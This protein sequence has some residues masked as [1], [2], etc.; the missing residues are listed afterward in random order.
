MMKA[1]LATVQHPGGFPQ[2]DLTLRDAKHQVVFTSSP[3]APDTS[4]TSAASRWSSSTANCSS[5]RRPFEVEPETWTLQTGF[6]T[7]PSRRSPSAS[8]R[9]QLA[10]MAL[11][12]AVMAAGV[13]FVAGA[14]ARE[15]RLAELKS[16]F[17]ATV[18]HDLK[19]PLALI[20]LFAETLELGRVRTPSGPRSTTASSTAR[21]RSSRA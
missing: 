18:S 13:F 11:L 3:E 20:Q 15:V 6:G 1:R 9:P 12:A 7:A 10:L 17:V 5:T 16:N 14:A 8:S 4:S 19:T 21:R 2:L